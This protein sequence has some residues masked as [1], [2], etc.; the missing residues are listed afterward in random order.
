MSVN[1][2][3]IKLK[4]EGYRVETQPNEEIEGT[5]KLII[6]KGE[7]SYYEELYKGLLDGSLT[8][9]KAPAS[10]TSL[11]SYRFATFTDLKEIDLTGITEIPDYLC[12]NCPNVDYFKLNTESIITVLNS[13]CFSRF[14]YNRESPEN[15]IFE[16]DF[17]NSTF[18]SIG[19]NAFEGGTSITA[20]KYF[21][22]Q[23]PVTLNSIGDNA[24]QYTD[25]FNIYFNS[26]SVPTIQSNTFS[27]T[28]N[29]KIFVPYNS[30]NTYKTATNWTTV[31]DSIYGFVNENTLETGYVLPTT[32]DEGLNLKW[33]SDIAMTTEV[34]TVTDTTIKYY[35]KINTVVN[36]P[37]SSFEIDGNTITKFVGSETDV[38]IPSSYSIDGYTPNTLTFNNT[39]EFEDYCETNRDYLMENSIE[40]TSVPLGVTVSI[41]YNNYMDYLNEAYFPVTAVIGMIPNIVDGNDYSI[42]SIGNQAFRYNMSLRSVEIPNTITSIGNYAFD[43]CSN[44]T[45]VDF[46]KATGLTSI[47]IDAFFG[48]S[49]LTGI[50]IPNSVTSI[51]RDAFHGCRSLISITIPTSV[52]SI[53][54]YAF[55]YCDALT[56]IVV[57]KD[58]TVYDSRDNCNA[59]IETATN[60]LIAGCQS[61]V[62]PNSVTSIRHGVFA[63]C[64]NLTSITIPSSVTSIGNGV[65]DGCS[66]LTSL[67]ISEG[68]I[69]IG[70]NTFLNCTSLTNVIIPNSVTSMGSG[71]FFGC[72]NLSSITIPSGI[73]S[74]NEQT[75]YRC[76]SLTNVVIPENVSYINQQAFYECNSLSE[77]IIK[78]T[79]PPTLSNTNAISSATTTIYIPH[80]TLSAY[81]SATNWSS[82]ASK[83]VELNADGSIPA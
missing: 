69:D 11:A 5:N 38:V 63:G 35:C 76:T 7:D 14:G 45:N 21:N 31:A 34:A 74:I 17:R 8:S 33:Y 1:N 30:I 55:Q 19:Q 49:N 2:L 67:T 59:I 39:S 25:H 23:F 62:I 20:N 61:T 9:F 50:T 72:S 16:F 46:S 18:N 24:F 6:T 78:S 70:F 51:G 57:E 80:G 12:F 83:F 66:N 65:F 81:Q 43:A 44:L 42:T 53:G 40:C 73:N 26:A 52:T 36:T 58:N 71:L 60:T 82:F 75:F 4:Q 28:T 48:C 27:N 68:V 37:F 29:N 32:N 54:H 41:N 56:N 3:L 22:I 77:M 10:I 64:S 15:N 13:Y 47:G 79:T